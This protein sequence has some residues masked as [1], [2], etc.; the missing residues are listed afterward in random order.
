MAVTI[1]RVQKDFGKENQHRTV[2]IV[3]FEWTS[4]GSGNASSPVDL[5]GFLVKAITNP[6][7][8]A[9]PTDDYDITL[10]DPN[11]A[12]LDALASTLA[13]RDTSN[14]EQVYPFVSG[15][16]TPIFLSG[17]YTF[18]VANAGASK[19]GVAIFYLVDSL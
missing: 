14:T 9:A 19:A 2:E 6:D 4:D 13:N 11:D 15:A 18:T 3:T 8:T 16:P 12:S 10:A 17:T 1:T 7:G 5:Q